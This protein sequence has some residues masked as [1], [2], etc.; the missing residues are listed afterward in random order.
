MSEEIKHMQAERKMYEDQVKTLQNQNLS[1]QDQLKR[2]T[3]EINFLRSQLNA[4][5]QSQQTPV[6]AHS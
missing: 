4:Q 3:E 1:Q 5:G 6:T 2:Q